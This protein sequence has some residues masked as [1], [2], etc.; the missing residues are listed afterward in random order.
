MIVFKE[1][2]TETYKC[3]ASDIDYRGDC[4]VFT[5]PANLVK[6][7]RSKNVG[8]IHAKLKIVNMDS[9]STMIKESDLKRLYALG[10]RQMTNFA[11]FFHMC[12]KVMTENRKPYCPECFVPKSNR[13]KCLN[14]AM[15]EKR[16]NF[17]KANR[18]KYPFC[19]GNWILDPY[20]FWVVLETSEDPIIN[21]NLKNQCK[22][23]TNLL[24]R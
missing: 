3:P 14:T 12:S 6:L 17:V 21:Q 15:C 24:S 16:Q 22:E 20:T 10:L 1:P 5:C 8:C 19:V 11:R 9:F 23:L 2:N 18:V 4:R 7:T 13:N